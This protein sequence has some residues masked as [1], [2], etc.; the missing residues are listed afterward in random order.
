VYFS[1]RERA[2]WFYRPTQEAFFRLFFFVC[3]RV[4]VCVWLLL[5]IFECNENII[6][7]IRFQQ[8]R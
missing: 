1:L 6:V 3:V 8:R 5:P 2:F 7:A 4:C